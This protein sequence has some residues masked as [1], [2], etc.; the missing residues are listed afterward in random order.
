MPASILDAPKSIFRPFSRQEFD[1][2]RAFVENVRRLGTMRFFKEVPQQATQIIGDNGMFSEMDEP[3][4][5]AVRA[6]IT[7][8]RQIYDHK[9]PNSFQRAMKVL[10]RSAHELNGPDREA[11]IAL[12]DSHLQAERDAINMGIGLG[13]TF[14]KRG[15]QEAISPRQII[16]AYFHGHYLHSGNAKSELAKRLD[17]LQPWPRYTLYTVMLRLH[18][19]Y[20]PS[21]NAAERVLKEPTLL[22]ASL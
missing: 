11:A 21:A 9:E 14:E 4:D 12:L 5:E 17:E 6:A 20:W 16:D 13:I 1:V 8:F 3:D 19:V 15:E 10:K 18:N 22:D 7:Q 2:L